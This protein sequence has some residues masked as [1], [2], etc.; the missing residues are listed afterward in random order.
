MTSWSASAYPPPPRRSRSRS[1]S[2][3]A[4]PP[5]THMDPAYGQDP[6]RADWDTYDR[7]R[8]WPGYERDRPVYDY[9]RRGRSR[10][11]SQ[12][13]DSMPQCRPL[14]EYCTKVPTPDPGRKRR[15]SLSPYERDRYDPR[16]RYNEEYGVLQTLSDCYRSSLTHFSQTHILVHMA[17]VHPVGVNTMLPFQMPDVHHLIPIPLTIR[18]P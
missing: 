12:L 11:P 16:P 1:P 15:R 13:D 9:G 6:Y 4:Y 10:S 18:R 7:D 5:R 3:G 8:A 14:T 2:R 17:I